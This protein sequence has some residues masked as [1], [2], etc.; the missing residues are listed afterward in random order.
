MRLGKVH[1][2]HSYVV[3]LDNKDMVEHAMDSL[4]E[5]LMNSYKREKL[6]TLI[7]AVEAPEANESEIPDFLTED[8][9]V[10]DD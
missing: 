4:H 6:Y 3:D 8:A 10:D 7:K 2:S 1:I 5:D 9:Q